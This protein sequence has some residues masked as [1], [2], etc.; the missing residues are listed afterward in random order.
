MQRTVLK[1]SNGSYH[2]FNLAIDGIV[3]YW[4]AGEPDWCYLQMSRGAAPLR[5]FG[6]V[7]EIDACYSAATTTP[8]PAGHP[9]PA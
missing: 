5:V 3:G 9:A 7:A 1:L 4:P 2:P 6:T 8:I